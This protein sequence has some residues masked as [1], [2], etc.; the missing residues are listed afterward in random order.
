MNISVIC[1]SYPR[2][3]GDSMAPFVRSISEGLMN[4][5]NR[6]E[7]V[8]PYDNAVEL[9]QDTRLPVHRFK[10]SFVDQ[11]N[12]MGHAKALEGDNTLKAGAYFLII[13][14]LITG[15][16]ELL[17]STKRNRSEA[18]HAHWSIPN[19]LI[20]LIVS[21]IRRI[22]YIVSLHG[23][24][25]FV[26]KK[27][28]LF[29]AI[30]KMVLKNAKAITACSQELYGY[31]QANG[32]SGRT[33]LIAWGAD[34]NIYIPVSDKRILREQAGVPKDGLIIS[35][36]GRLV[37]KKGFNVLIEAFAKAD[38]TKNTYLLIGGSGPQDTTLRR[39]AENLGVTDRVIFPGPIAWR[40]TPNFLNI[41]DIFVLPSI[42]DPHGNM[43]GLPTV[44]LEAMSCGQACIASDIGGVHLVVKHTKNGLLVRESSVEDLIVA[45]NKL[46]KDRKLCSELGRAARRSIMDTFNWDNVSVKIREILN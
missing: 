23:S 31:S 7:I 9:D 39:L 8:A 15:T 43:D 34:P 22:P 10:Y 44:L 6:L 33:H 20:G 41:G 38:T 28:Y 37:P 35:A 32:G 12:I 46:I 17:R 25:I 11:W 30:N 14:Y 19:G 29:G 24:D 18:I 1:S 45:L 26:S 5:G 3:A 36:L 13:P 16:F 4:L 27:N 40:D 2:Y 21:K 42:R